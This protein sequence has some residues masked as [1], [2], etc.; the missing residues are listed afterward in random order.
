MKCEDPFI[1]GGLAFPCQKCEA[2]LFNRRRVW[3]HRIMLE[4]VQYEDNAFV[5]LTYDDE[6]L[7]MVD[8][9]LYGGPGLLP[10][11]SLRDTQLWHKRL[12]K[13]LAP[14]RYRYFL[15]GEYGSTTWRPH[16]HVALFGVPSCARGITGLGMVRPDW[17]RCC[18]A[19]R[20]VGETWEN[21]SVYLGVLEANSAQY[22]CSYVTKKMT[23]RDH[24]KL[25]G[26][27]PEFS[28]QSNRGG[29]LGIGALDEIASEWLRL[30]L[31]DRQADVPVSLAHG[32]R[33]LPLGR[34]LRRKLRAR[35]GKEENAPQSTLD[36]MAEEM[37]PLREVAFENSRSLKSEILNAQA[38]RVA[39]FHARM[40]IFS[41]RGSL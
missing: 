34:Y 7:P 36:Q 14:F 3:A 38:A 23:R 21:G 24:W 33:E 12:R 10:S 29:G 32:R 37:R 40:K 5:T 22:V 13:R 6:H 27:D 18:D 16:Y 11:L 28:K 30:N 2:C 39:S 20:L 8:S 4:A 31:D 1:K 15:A 35:V 25:L 17:K 19:C 26:R 41:Q 9:S